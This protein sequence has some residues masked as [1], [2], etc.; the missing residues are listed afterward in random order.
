MAG[1]LAG[2]SSCF[3][4][5]EVGKQTAA[6][7]AAAFQASSGNGEDEGRHRPQQSLPADCQ[8]GSKNEI[9]KFSAEI[10]MN[11]KVRTTIRFRC[12]EG[13]EPHIMLFIDKKG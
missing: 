2:C 5:V 10:Q 11:S 9:I 4:V 8:M 1:R 3:F 6:F 13:E 7:I 12:C